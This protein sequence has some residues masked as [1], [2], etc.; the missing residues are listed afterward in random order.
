M[1][2]GLY[3]S[4]WS[5]ALGRKCARSAVGSSGALSVSADKMRGPQPIA[6]WGMVMSTKSPATAHEGPGSGGM[7]RTPTRGTNR[8]WSNHRSVRSTSTVS[9]DGRRS[10]RSSSCSGLCME[11]ASARAQ[12]TNASWRSSIMW[13]GLSTPN[14][15]VERGSSKSSGAMSLVLSNSAPAARHCV[16][17]L[18]F[19][20]NVEAVSVVDGVLHPQVEDLG[21]ASEFDVVFG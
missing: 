10:L 21:L 17:W 9:N 12:V 3:R 6:C 15:V 1:V 11:A 16:G 20:Q 13:G 2:V 19:A 7:A 5:I 18:G 8:L 4:A 14:P